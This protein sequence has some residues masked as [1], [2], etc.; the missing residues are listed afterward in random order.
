MAI[1]DLARKALPD[2]LYLWLANRYR[3]LL[4]LVAYPKSAR[5]GDNDYDIYWDNKA[6]SGSGHLSSWRRK[7]AE[8]FTSLVEA[9]DRVLDLGVGSA[10]VY[11]RSQK[12]RWLLRDPENLLNS[13]KSYRRKAIVVSIPNT[14]LHQH[15]LRPLLG[16]IYLCAE[17][18]TLT[19]FQN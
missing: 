19:R 16:S 15:G 7:R 8:I 17:I 3:G 2:G 12:D 18:Y 6:K 4:R 11:D 10:S 14:G 5:V 9:G 1:K 13:L